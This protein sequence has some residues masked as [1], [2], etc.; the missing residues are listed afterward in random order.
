MDAEVKAILEEAEEYE[1]K[2]HKRMRGHPFRDYIRESAYN[3]ITKAEVRRTIR[4]DGEVLSIPTHDRYL[5]D[6]IIKNAIRVEYNEQRNEELRARKEKKTRNEGI[7][8]CE[9]IIEAA[10]SLDFKNMTEEDVKLAQL[11]I[12]AAGKLPLLRKS[13]PQTFDDEV[14]A[15]QLSGEDEQFVKTIGDALATR[16]TNG[17]KESSQ[18]SK[19]NSEV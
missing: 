19:D 14:K 1:L 7:D 12:N 11:A 4:E 6:P 17:T 8:L 5:N 9:E 3:G 18:E 15:A 16:S 2:N 13:E 10:R